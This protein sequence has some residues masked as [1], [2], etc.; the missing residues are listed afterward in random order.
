MKLVR[1]GEPGNERPGIIDEQGARR[2]CSEFARDWDGK[3]FQDDGLRRLGVWLKGRSASLPVVAADV[4]YGSCIARPGKIVCIGLNYRDHAAEADMDLPKEPL[5]F[6]KAPNT[7]VGPCDDILL[8]RGSS[9]VDWEIEVGVVVGRN[10]RYLSS[11]EEAE[12]YIAGYC[13]S[14]DV[15]ERDFQFNRG[16]Q[17][18][19][20]KSC[21][22][23]NPLGPWLLTADE[24]KDILR[25]PMTLKVNG[26]VKQAG[27]TS[28][29]IFKPA[30]ILHYLSQFM[31]LEAGDL[32]TTGTPAGVGF[33]RKPR[34]F[35]KA[36]DIVSLSIQG[37]GIQCQKCCNV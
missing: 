23:F 11:S 21:D 26:V 10:A 31:T 15:S 25:S 17:W 30:E 7:V 4:R 9:Q 22:S 5:I 14:H 16:G 18:T 12:L 3:F 24:A 8:P 1:L 32:I 2:D 34:E 20:G 27:S 19:K 6:L 29:M 35:L 36:G 33:G 13:I 28:A 37:L